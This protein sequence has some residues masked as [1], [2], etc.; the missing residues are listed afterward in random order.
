M[1]L[2]PQ[3]QNTPGFTDFL[4]RFTSMRHGEEQNQRAW[5]NT[6][7]N[8]ARQQAFEKQQARAEKTFEFEMERAQR[9][10]Q[11]EDVAFNSQLETR[12]MELETAASDMEREL[13][14]REEA[15]G[16]LDRFT[17][18]LEELMLHNDPATFAQARSAFNQRYASFA[19][20]GE[21]YE[22]R[23]NRASES[24]RV[25]GDQLRARQLAEL[26][27]QGRGFTERSAAEAQFPQH[28]IDEQ[29]M[30]DGTTRY[31]A[32]NQLTPS[33]NGQRFTAMQR[34]AGIQTE[35]GLQEALTEMS[36]SPWLLSDPTVQAAFVQQR[37][38]VSERTAARQNTQDPSAIAREIMQGT[39]SPDWSVDV[40]REVEDSSEQGEIIAEAFEHAQT[41]GVPAQDLRTRINFILRAFGRETFG[42]E[43]PTSE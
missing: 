11:L 32:T 5:I 43:P 8:Q 24:L 7:I 25:R 6:R 31:V 23:V 26:S 40:L 2:V 28:V 42:S 30:P 1:V 12:R 27:D 16:N 4:Q 15:A 10:A 13:A 39:W 19:L 22:Q 21:E 41:I 17:T 9:R 38:A 34:I 18:D 37:R 14:Y 35:E 36:D 29:Q 20:A 33:A 3:N